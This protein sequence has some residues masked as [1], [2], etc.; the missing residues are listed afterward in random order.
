MNDI[1]MT[2]ER[3]QELSNAAPERYTGLRAVAESLS[4]RNVDAATCELFNEAL[5]R[6]MALAYEEDA[7]GYC[8]IDRVTGKILIPLPWGRNGYAKWGLRPQEANIL[9]EILFTWQREA[10]TLFFYDRLRRAW[11]VNVGDYA[12]IHLAKQWL[13]RHQVS[14]GVYRAARAK[15]LAGG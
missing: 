4:L 15:R 9:R 1:S 3:K 6:L 10:P 13:V 12:N 2:L 7:G 8:N 5:A 14:I 11:F